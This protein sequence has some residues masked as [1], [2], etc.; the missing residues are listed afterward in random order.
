MEPILR[1]SMKRVSP[2]ARLRW[3]RWRSALFVLGKEPEADGDLGG[4]EELAGQG[5]HAVDEVVLHQFLADGSFA[6]GVGGHGPV[7]E[8][9]PGGAVLGEL[10]QPCGESRRSW[11]CR[12]A[13]YR[14]RPSVGSVV[15]SSSAA[16]VLQVEGWVGHD[17]VGLEVGVLVLEEGIGGDFPEVGGEAAHGEVHLGQL[18]GGGGDLLPVDGDVLGVAVV[19]ST[20]LS[21]CTN[22][23]PGAAAGVV[24]LALVGLDHFGRSG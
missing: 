3:P 13:G 7:G 12:W 18:V 24:D 2:L 9:E 15:S 20:N 22:M 5:D 8:D 1:A 23:P 10:G 21:D 4:E 16:P 11:H 19:A 17:V 6:R 14:S